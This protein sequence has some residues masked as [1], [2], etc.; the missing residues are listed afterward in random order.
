MTENNTSG[1]TLN[2]TNYIYKN[3]R[4]QYVKTYTK[5]DKLYIYIKMR[6]NNTSRRTLNTTNYIYKNE[7]KQY[8]RTYTKY[9]KP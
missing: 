3:E 2:T 8:V 6:E 4:K 5:Y 9:D 7:R 1:R